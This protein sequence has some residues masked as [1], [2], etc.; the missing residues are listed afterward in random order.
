MT[1]FVLH[2]GAAFSPPVQDKY[3]P[4]PGTITFMDEDVASVSTAGPAL[5]IALDF[6]N[7]RAAGREQVVVVRLRDVKGYF[8]TDYPEYTDPDDNLAVSATVRMDARGSAEKVVV[9]IPYLTMPR[10]SG[11]ITEAEI[12]VHEPSGPLAALNFYHLDLPDDFDRVPDLLTVVAHTMVA[13]SR[14]SGRLTREHVKVIRELLQANFHLEGLGDQALRRILKIANSTEH[15]PATLAEAIRHIVPEENHARLVNLVYACG[16][17]AGPMGAAEQRFVSELLERCGI[18]DFR[19][20]GPAHLADAY[21]ELELDPG[22]ELAVVKKTYKQ[23][24]R[25]YHPDRVH[26]LAKGFRDFAHDKTQR[27]NDAY[28]RIRDVLERTTEVVVE[29]DE[30]P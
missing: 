25:D 18:H 10:D 26:N 23:L 22:T 29:L 5:T 1:E 20:F 21:K 6:H 13:L 24:V 4:P 12:A 14:V 3:R 15:S 28:R 2:T 8:P 16:E 17:A 27:L 11:G 19:R 9:V 7:P 30:E